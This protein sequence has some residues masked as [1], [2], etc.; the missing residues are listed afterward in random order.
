MPSALESVEQGQSKKLTEPPQALGVSV[1]VPISERCEHLVEIYES[2]AA[3]LTQAGYSFEFLFVVDG[4]F[5]YACEV[6]QPLIARG[7][8]IH[9]VTLARAFGEATAL[10]VGFKQAQ[11]NILVCL[12]SYLQ[13]VPEGILS[14]L[15]AVE[16]GYDLAVARR[17][18]RKDSWSNRLQNYL[19]HQAIHWLTNLTFHDMGCSLKAMTRQVTRELP[20]YGDLHRFIP[21]LAYQRGFRIAEV[22]VPQHPADMKTRIYRPGVYLRRLL[23]ILTVV[24]LVKFTRKPLRFFGL[25]AAGLFSTGF[26]LSLA[27]TVQKLLGSVSLSDK[28]LLILGVLLMVLGVQTGSIGLLGEIIIFTHARRMKEYTIETFLK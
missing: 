3:V 2:H 18:P 1:V 9:V 15:H 24:F 4:G 10:A 17:W 16:R 6:L 5:E 7:E 21:M 22:E 13:T 27:L 8:P 26:C 28:P 14:V 23:D 11:A 12:P 25:I 20:L 19:F